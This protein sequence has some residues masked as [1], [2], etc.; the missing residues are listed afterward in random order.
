MTTEERGGSS[1]CDLSANCT[2][3]PQAFI[4]RRKDNVAGHCFVGVAFRRTKMRFVCVFALKAT[5][6]T[7][8]P[9]FIY[10][11]IY[12]SLARKGSCVQR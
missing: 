11:F 7:T 4:Y 6:A 2:L 5:N 3:T 10:S 8:R 1:A 9:F 12:F